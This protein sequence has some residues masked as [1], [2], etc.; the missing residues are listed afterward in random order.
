MWSEKNDYDIYFTSY[1]NFSLQSMSIT[2]TQLH[3]QITA[4]L[5]LVISFSSNKVSI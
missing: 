1:I 5:E 4:V 2:I 3:G